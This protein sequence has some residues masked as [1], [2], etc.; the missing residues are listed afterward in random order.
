MSDRE[1]ANQLVEIIIS[2][3]MDYDDLKMLSTAIKNK[4]SAMQCIQAVAFNHDDH[5]SFFDKK[6]S[7]TVFGKVAGINLK[8]ITVK[9]D[10]NVI[11]KVSPSLLK[12]VS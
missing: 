6:R 10:Q 1:I 5:V 9:S 3:E 11:W 7:R 12:K 8:T 2:S 4:W